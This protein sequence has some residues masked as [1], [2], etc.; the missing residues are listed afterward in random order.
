MSNPIV[1]KE[2]VQGVHR[3]RTYALRAGLAGLGVGVMMI[4]LAQVIL[5]GQ[6]SWIAVARAARPVFV[7]ISWMELGVFPLLGAL[8]AASSLRSE[9][10]RKTIDVLRTTPL[11][12]S[13]IVYG[14]FAAVVGKL[15]LMAVALLPIQILAS[16][17]GRVP[18]ELALRTIGL[19]ASTTL[20]LA[21][22]AML[23]ASSPL[24]RRPTSGITLDVLVLSS[25]AAI[26]LAYG[27]GNAQPEV[28]ALV[29]PW[30]FYFVLT[31]TAP[32][33]LSP[34]HFATL[35]IAAPLAAAAMCLGLSPLALRRAL[36][37]T[38]ESLTKVSSKDDRRR[39]RP[40][41]EPEG[42]PFLWQENAPSRRRLRLTT[43]G[44]LTLHLIL[45]FL[46]WVDWAATGQFTGGMATLW[47]AVAPFIAVAQSLAIA[48]LAGRTLVDEKRHGC[49]G[50]LVLTGNSPAR[51]VRGKLRA[52]LRVFRL[53]F[54]LSGLTIATWLCLCAFLFE[55]NPVFGISLDVVVPVWLATS[56]IVS[57]LRLA[58]FSVAIGAAARSVA[59]LVI[60]VVVPY[61]TLYVFH[62]FMLYAIIN[63]LMN[64]RMRTGFPGGLPPSPVYAIVILAVVGF[65]GYLAVRIVVRRI[66]RATPR[67]APNVWRYCVVHIALVTAL[68]SASL[69]LSLVIGGGMGA[70][71]AIDL[72]GAI[73][74]TVF[75]YAIARRDFERAMLNRE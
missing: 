10:T 1:I 29:P 63:Q 15:L 71:C 73:G 36:V 11:S 14:K 41:L 44:L 20:C 65:M 24:R 17:I 57:P 60:A 19:V 4:A 47:R 3:K 35:A 12:A 9:R 68:S 61:V 66:R 72:L 53:P 49:A 62:R 30:A 38:S 75:W 50:L 21:A 26:A 2:L 23:D 18:S 6:Q 22:L 25:G 32:G 42:D 69:V 43:Q 67:G 46:S 51:I 59:A 40:A 58:V 45:F 8:Y 5:P 13:Q 7:S 48:L 34:P 27:L 74:I 54:L 39:P 56:F 52:M 37:R 55:S 31:G 16:Q 28:I 70:Q 64:L 33:G